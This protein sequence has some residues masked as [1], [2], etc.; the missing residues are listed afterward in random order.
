MLYLILQGFRIWGCHDLPGNGMFT[1]PNPSYIDI[2]TQCYRKMAEM[3]RPMDFW[4]GM[5]LSSNIAL[6]DDNLQIMILD[7]CANSNLFRLS[8]LWGIRICKS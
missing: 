6:L 4:K 3:R 7:S 2:F 1:S 5:V 8:P